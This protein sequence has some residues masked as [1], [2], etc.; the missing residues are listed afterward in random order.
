MNIKQ[1]M[2]ADGLPNTAVLAINSAVEPLPLTPVS[3]SAM[4]TLT[5]RSGIT[6]RDLNVLN[7]DTVNALITQQSSTNGVLSDATRLAQ[8]II[9]GVAG[10]TLS[11]VVG[12]G[13]QIKP[14]A[15]EFLQSKLNMGLSFQ[16]AVGNN[17]LTGNFGARTVSDLVNNTQGQIAAIQT[18]LTNS[19]TSLINTGVISGL[20]SAGQ[21]G[22]LILAGSAFGPKAVTDVVS[23]IT[24]SISGAVSNIAGGISGAVSNI[25]GG[26]TGAVSNITGSITGAIG[27]VTNSIQG[28][29]NMI[30][31]GNF[32][33]AITDKLSGGLG[34]LASSLTGS[35]TGA[36]GSVGGIVGGALGGAIGKLFGGKGS[37]TVSV[38]QLKQQLS[39]SSRSAYLTTEQSLVGTMKPGEPNYLAGDAPKAQTSSSE[40]VAN[41][42]RASELELELADSELIQAR[43]EYTQNPSAENKAALSAAEAKFAQIKKQQAQ[44][45]SD[46]LSPKPK[47]SGGLF[48]GLKN[49]LSGITQQIGNIQDTVQQ[50]VTQGIS[51]VNNVVNAAT[52]VSTAYATGGL[53]LLSNTKLGESLGKLAN[54]SQL[55]GDITGKF[56]GALSGITDIGG[57]LGSI[58]AGAGD[59]LK[60]I[61]GGF[62]KSPGVKSPAYADNTDNKRAAVAANTGQLLGDPVVPPP[63]TVT[64]ET[65]T[66]ITPNQYVRSQAN[67]IQ[68][69][70]DLEA[71]RAIQQ[72]K[73]DKL[74]AD[75][76]QTPSN[77]SKLSELNSAR[78]KLASIDQQI[79]RAQLLYENIVRGA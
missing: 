22:G 64:G 7:S 53:S 40:A 73:I 33:G 51:T 44:L 39:S 35:L 68:T 48:G 30:S 9:P 42:L 76:T 11:Q 20:E 1:S 3:M 75:T 62:G 52:V 54:P 49:P 60:G 72:L 61:L 5:S 45:A 78:N 56:T 31:S 15:E 4:S 34:G 77:S 32:V 29:G 65:S 13:M 27:S 18:S 10:A 46:I 43:I 2:Q 14:G 24:G 50:T 63:P 38:D 57:K 16:S 21:I 23:S 79:A 74:L 28:I 69:L 6:V 59:K 25:T 19:A 26:I 71:Q 37:S 70:D 41:Q 66:D 36:L 17:M 67:A 55:V 12:P 47:K 58:A 8:G